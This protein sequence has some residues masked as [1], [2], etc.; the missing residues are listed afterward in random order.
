MY[1]TY[2][3]IDNIND[4]SINKLVSS[5]LSEGDSIDHLY[6]NISS[7]GG[8]VTPAI[9][10]YNFLKKCP[11]R[12]TTHNLGEVTSAAVIMYLA[13]STRTAEK[14]SKFVMHPIKGC[15]ARDLSYY[16]L[17]ELVQLIDAD[18][19]N[20]AL[21]VNQET[22]S[23]NGLYD[24]EECLKGNSITLHPQS[25]YQCGIITQMSA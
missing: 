15:M 10:A 6:L 13:G 25:A 4:D 14:I 11:F 18:I 12:V 7:L 17:Q 1:M 8:S 20:Y 22:N 16:Q 5:I 21:I 23:L 19:K 24:I 9:T 3:F 2:N